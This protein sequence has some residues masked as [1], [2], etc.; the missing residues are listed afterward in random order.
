MSTRKKLHNN[1]LIAKTHD[2]CFS[3]V[4]SNQTENISH[5]FLL[6]VSS[7]SP[8]ALVRL[9]EVDLGEAGLTTDQ[10]TAVLLEVGESPDLRLKTTRHPDSVS[11]LLHHEE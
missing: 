11:S 8:K 2:L 5:Q 10:V 7:H 3:E 9:E 6:R 4:K 1:S